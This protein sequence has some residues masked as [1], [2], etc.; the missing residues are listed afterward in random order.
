MDVGSACSVTYQC[1]ETIILN[2][3]NTT[4][5]MTCTIDLTLEL[6]LVTCKGE[7]TVI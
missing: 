3:I 7:E 2:D 4:Y 6:V 1:G 5:C